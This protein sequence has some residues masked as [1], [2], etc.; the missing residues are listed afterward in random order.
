M[1]IVL[2]INSFQNILFK[3]LTVFLKIF[4]FCPTQ[5]IAVTRTWNI[6]I[7]LQIFLSYSL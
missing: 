6:R 4:L 2:N 5:K 3:K 7:V 1:C